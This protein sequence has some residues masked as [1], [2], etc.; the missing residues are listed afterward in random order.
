M[1]F[2]DE[3][4]AEPAEA[5]VLRGPALVGVHGLVHAGAGAVQEEVLVFVLPQHDRGRGA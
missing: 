5:A 1:R 4:S 3:V 2:D